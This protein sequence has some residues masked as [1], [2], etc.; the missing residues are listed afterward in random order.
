[1]TENT[2]IAFCAGTLCA[3]LYY[4]NKVCKCVFPN[5]PLVGRYCIFEIDILW[6][7]EFWFIFSRSLLICPRLYWNCINN[8]HSI[9]I[10]DSNWEKELRIQNGTKGK[11]YKD[12]TLNVFQKIYYTHPDIKTDIFFDTPLHSP[13]LWPQ[14]K[15]CRLQLP[16][17]F[18]FQFMF[19][20]DS[21]GPERPPHLHCQKLWS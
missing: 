14:I 2:K 5:T 21:I 20:E 3:W 10:C 6:F 15:S 1:M 17:Q 9:N 19:A 12:C 8:T 18:T 7:C 13:G 4:T 16:H 11:I